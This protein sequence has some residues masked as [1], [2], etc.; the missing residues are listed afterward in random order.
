MN[1]LFN[2][3]FK[4]YSESFKKI[5]YTEVFDNL[6]SLLL[7]LHIIDLIIKENQA[8]EDYWQQF[9]EMFRK[10]ESNYDRF[11]MNKKMLKKV[12]K[13]CEKIYSTLMHGNVF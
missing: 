6:G 8:F 12:Q 5:Q 9:T 1:G 11:N 4:P 7:N 10:V 13:F 2:S 3:K